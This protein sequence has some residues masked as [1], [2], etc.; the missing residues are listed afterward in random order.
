MAL[1]TVNGTQHG[2]RTG[3]GPTLLDFLRT[4]LRLSGAKPGCGEGECGACTVLRD[5]EPVFACRT[6]LAD[7]EG[8]SI[9]TVEGLADLGRLHPVQ[10]ALAREHAF[11]CGYCIP[12][13][14]LRAVAL[15]S[16]DANPE[17]GQLVTAMNPSVCRCGCYRRMVSAIRAVTGE[18]DRGELAPAPETADRPVLP[19]PRRPWDLCE[20]EE[21]DWF[22]ILGDG[23]VA[24]WPPPPQAP[25]VWSTGGGAWLHISPA[26]LVTAFS[27]KVDV[28]QDNTT[29]FALLVAEELSVGLR[30]VRMVV[31]DTDLCPFDLGTFG[32]R[33]MPD[34]GEALRRAAAGARQSLLRLGAERWG[35]PAQQ[36]GASD[37]FIVGGRGQARLSYG[38]LLSGTQRVEALTTEPELTRP[39]EWRTAGRS[40]A[41][42][43]AIDVVTGTRLFVS[44]LDR[45]GL[46]HGAVLRPPAPGRTL[47]EADPS[48][49]QGLSDVFV[50]REGDFVGAVAPSPLAARQA[51]AAVRAEWV[52]PER[53]PDDLISHLRSHPAVSQGW[54]G[55][56]DEVFGDV[57]GALARAAVRLRASYTT[58]YLAHTPLETRAAIAEWESGRL[59]VWTGTQVPFGVR[60]QLA[61][62]LGVREAD[63]RVIVPPTGG[64][65]GGKHRG[66]VAVEAARLARVVGRPVKVH[67]NRREEFQWGY[68]RPMAVIDVVSG[69]DDSGSITAWDFTNI[70]SGAAGIACP[71]RTPNQRL[72]FQ[73]AASPLAQGSYRALAATANHF[74]RESH[75][76]ELAHA[77][78]SDP[79]DF[80]LRNL[81]DERL[82]AVVQTA[83]ARFG[84]S[85][86]A[87]R[88][89]IAAGL[90]K[91]GR[92]A[93]CAEVSVDAN[94]RVE[95]VRVVTAYECGAVVNPDTVT[96][97]IE[98]ATVM[99]LGGALFEE[100]SVDGG[101]IADPS[102]SGY[103]VPR[104]SDVPEIEVVLV[105][106]PDIPP[107]G[108]GE[109]PMVAVAPA[110]ANA[111]F[112][113]SGRRLRSLPLAPG[114]VLP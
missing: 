37:G 96:N 54:E 80:R 15:L 114:E 11:Q 48:D 14:A 38:A 109:T 108:A 26:G 76:D 16:G 110:V 70:N 87:G 45:P 93:T 101:Q 12:G 2:L 77:T 89:G 113:T 13:V 40:P 17:Y 90:E 81:A 99:A 5:G 84:W 74:A 72:R 69:L 60:S 52:E 7:L 103:R 107:A 104:F 95:V 67:W 9:T 42:C 39:E 21:R 19:R 64:G 24:V 41:G 68:L 83:A 98:G 30:H 4:E 62:E 92:V 23:L 10:A 63:V 36:L 33:S 79:V 73:P 29:A 51:L 61:E 78:G 71:Y 55:A 94:H 57:D 59:T 46:L 65:F 85:E 102:L 105:H 112:T 27:G 50:V 44:D 31:G 3:S 34:A 58:A 100:V 86:S 75:I 88:S 1:I 28:G 106:R 49:A 56:V 91:G 25:G 66:Q 8:S 32:S 97:Q 35:V 111:V 43:Y 22:E 82:A 20:P 53:G 47:L 18:A 6:A